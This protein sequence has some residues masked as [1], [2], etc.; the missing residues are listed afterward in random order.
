MEKVLPGVCFEVS[1]VYS[2]REKNQ[3]PLWM[4]RCIGA[5]IKA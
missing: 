1:T 4:I 5:G 2:K 3:K